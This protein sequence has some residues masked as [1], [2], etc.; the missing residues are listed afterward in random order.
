[1]L[2]LSNM[3]LAALGLL[4]LAGYELASR[5]KKPQQPKQEE[6]KPAFQDGSDAHT[7]MNAFYSGS[8]APAM[9][10]YAN[11]LGIHTGSNLMEHASRNCRPE[12]TNLFNPVHDLSFVNG[13][14][15]VDNKDRYEVSNKMHNVLPFEQKRVGPGLNVK[16]D[17]EFKGGF[18]QYFRVMPGNVNG[19]KKNNLPQ[20]IVP[21]R[22]MVEAREETPTVEAPKHDRY[23]EM[24]DRPLE[25]KKYQT[26]ALAKR[27]ITNHK[28]TTDV[29]DE[30]YFGTAHR[31][32]TYLSQDGHFTRDKDTAFRQEQHTNVVGQGQ[33]VN[34][35]AGILVSDTD[36]EAPG[37]DASNV[38]GKKMTYARDGTEQFTTTNRD[39]TGNNAHVSNATHVEASKG[40]LKG[41]QHAAQTHR[42]DTSTAYEGIA[43][44]LQKATDSR[45]YQANETQRQFTNAASVGHAKFYAN[46]AARTP[47]Q[48]QYTMKEDVVVG[49]APGPQGINKLVDPYKTVVD[50]K[51]D[52][53]NDTRVNVPMVKENT[54]DRRHIG[55]VEHELKFKEENPRMF[56]SVANVVLDTNPY[57]VKINK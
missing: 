40:Y 23:Y 39:I 56:L 1:M 51:T 15:N 31:N 20:R 7:N 11:K 25:H 49:Y 4:S 35:V 24:K 38:V 36:R 55:V 17:V 37:H 22:K 53:M 18:H 21:G 9:R 33:K 19:Y 50:L 45:E 57:A 34:N 12:P 13:A 30:V 42:N 44:G 43:H 27:P 26:H 2:V 47:G 6:P 28:H 16:S 48:E 29:V 3:D 32:D 46:N 54:S 8:Q 41:T 14:P 10:G 5:K 52:A